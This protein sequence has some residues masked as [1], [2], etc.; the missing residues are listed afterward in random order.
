ME[1]FSST[2]PLGDVDQA[3]KAQDCDEQRSESTPGRF[4]KQVRPLH[5]QVQ[6]ASAQFRA[7]TCR[8]ED[9]RVAIEDLY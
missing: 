1:A 2:C 5:V 9:S 3:L 4:V 8:H 6:Y 7:T